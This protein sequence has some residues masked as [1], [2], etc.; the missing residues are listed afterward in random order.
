MNKD[1]KNISITDIKH[2]I[3]HEYIYKDIK[4]HVIYNDIKSDIIAIIELKYM[5]LINR[6]LKSW[7]GKNDKFYFLDLVAI[8]CFI[9][10]KHFNKT[11]SY[12]Y[13]TIT[14]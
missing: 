6:L 4:D 1:I 14:N 3:L 7:H 11:N 12:I 13:H 5:H 9:F 2:V 10:N 8:S